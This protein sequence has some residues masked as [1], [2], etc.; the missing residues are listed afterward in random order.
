MTHEILTRSKTRMLGAVF[1]EHINMFLVSAENKRKTDGDDY[2][3]SVN[4]R[5]TRRRLEHQFDEVA[6]NDYMDIC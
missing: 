1:W 2:D 3:N 4:I 6:N 5:N